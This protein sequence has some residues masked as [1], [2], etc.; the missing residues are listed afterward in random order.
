MR[1][2]PVEIQALRALGEAHRADE[3]VEFWSAGSLATGLFSC[4]ACG[5]TV[6]STYQLT[7]CPRCDG[8][9]WEDPETSPFEHL[10]LG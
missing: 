6:V 3:Y 8:T 5:W 4:V 1:D 7:P 2:A 10:V 9:L